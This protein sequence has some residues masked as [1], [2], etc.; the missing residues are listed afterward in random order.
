VYCVFVEHHADADGDE[1]SA[2][3]PDGDATSAGPDG[4]AD[5]VRTG[6]ANTDA[7]NDN[8][9][10]RFFMKLPQVLLMTCREPST[11]T[12]CEEYERRPVENLTQT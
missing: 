10:N 12:S 6:A 9:S 2:A 11:R 5:A 7:A 3:N 1:I 8:A 4:D